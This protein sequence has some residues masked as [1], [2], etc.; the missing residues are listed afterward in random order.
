MEITDWQT[1]SYVSFKHLLPFVFMLE[2]TEFI[3]KE[4]DCIVKTRFSEIEPRDFLGR[5]K[6][7][8]VRKTKRAAMFEGM[9]LV[10]YSM[11]ELADELAQSKKLFRETVRKRKIRILF[12]ITK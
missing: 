12:L 1:G 7:L 4:K 10:L 8:F 2:T 5:T 3:A 6:A 11:A 9:T